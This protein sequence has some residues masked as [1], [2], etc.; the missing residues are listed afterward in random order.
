MLNFRRYFDRSQ[1]ILTSIVCIIIALCTQYIFEGA[2][3]FHLTISFGY[4]ATFVFFSTSF[5]NAFPHWSDNKKIGATIAFGLVFGAANMLVWIY[6]RRGVWKWD[7]LFPVLLATACIA[8]FML[9]F[10][11]ARERAGRAESELKDIQL[12]QAEQEKALINSQLRNLQG[13]MEPHFLFNT[14]AN[15][16]VLID[17]DASKAKKLLEKITDLLRASLK[18]QRQDAIFIGDE[19]K[20]LDSYLSIQQIRLSERMSYE[21]VID[22][23][24]AT[25]TKF[26]PFLI[27][28]AVENAVVHGIEPSVK[29]GFI[30]LHFKQEGP[31]LIIEVT[32]N[33]LGFNDASK[34]HGLSMKNVRERLAALYGQNGKLELI[35]H[36]D[37]GF[38]TRISLVCAL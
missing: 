29:G 16:Q 25:Q 28:P 26:P 7:L 37:G 10:F 21:I 34:G 14:L 35:P 19:V 32:D 5:S 6:I 38:T 1:L 33:G 22:K 9:F 13:Q 24:I 8:L 27:Q 20:L 18:Q 36:K 11:F 30:R 17:S 3:F 12:R 2:L 23:N 4:G 15:I 31:Q